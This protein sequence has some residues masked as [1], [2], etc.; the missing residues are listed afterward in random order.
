MFRSKTK[1]PPVPA[2]PPT[3]DVAALAEQLSTARGR[4]ELLG[5]DAAS[6]LTEVP[7]EAEL[8]EARGLAVWKRGQLRQADR[9][10]LTAQLE[11]A[12]DIRAAEREI[13]AADIRDAI[14]ARKALA[15]QRRAET[16]A[17]TIAELHRYSR[18]TRY[19]CGAIIAAG[20]IWSAINVQHNMAP[21]G[22]SDPLYWVSFLIEGMI[23]GLL[24]I[25]A[26]GTAKVRDAADIEP[27][28]GIRWAEVGLFTLT[29]GLNTYPY[30]R[31][32]HWYDSMLHGIA[33]GLIGGTL[34][35]LH[36][37]GAD[38][39]RARGVVAQRIT[40][41][42][43]LHLPDL[44]ALHSVQATPLL[45]PAQ[46]ETAAAV[47][48][49]HGEETRTSTEPMAEFEREFVPAPEPAL[50]TASESAPHFADE[51]S[52][53]PH[54]TSLEVD[55]TPVVDA[56]AGAPHQE[57]AVAEVAVVEPAPHQPIE[58]SAVPAAPVQEETPAPASTEPSTTATSQE[59]APEP[60]S[61]GEV[62][63]SRGPRTR[64]AH[65][66]RSSG[67]GAGAP[68]S[69]GPRSQS[70]LA[71]ATVESAGDSAGTDSQVRGSMTALAEEVRGRGAGG[72]LPLETVVRVLE[73][74]TGG[75]SVNAAHTAT[76]VHRKTIERIRDTATVVRAEAA[77]STTG[78]RVIE[79]RKPADR[80]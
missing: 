50:T 20:M 4:L 10:E 26:L 11:A 40:D 25:I 30:V 21:G 33:P 54:R 36:Y 39:T 52:A 24:V 57:S 6:V 77:S 70:A 61:A 5:G 80:A 31:D 78:G 41:D 17:S 75:A 35:V 74:L 43:A 71:L 62:R 2:R 51:E 37:M 47:Q 42:A 9:A 1:T 34:W 63:A 60:A 7:S 49:H 68:A 27:S 72:R 58:E 18:W 46:S 22:T 67:A 23:S 65:P 55:S 44:R 12:E 69:A 53:A 76:G 15:A 73:V 28:A 3:G 29:F 64:T 79:L 13:R 38:Y 19:G 45:A 16:P 56:S 8:A 48:H 59:A 14:D 66:A 32:S